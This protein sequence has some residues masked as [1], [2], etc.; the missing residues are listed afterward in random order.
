M[1]WGFQNDSWWNSRDR[2]AQKLTRFLSCLWVS[3]VL[4]ELFLCSPLPLP[5]ST[6]TLVATGPSG[7]WLTSFTHCLPGLPLLSQMAAFASLKL[8]NKYSVYIW[9][10]FSPSIHHSA[11]SELAPQWP[12]GYCDYCCNEHSTTFISWW[13]S[14]NAT[15][16]QIQECWVMWHV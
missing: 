11:D 16:T 3:A 8:N 6:S 14:L 2:Q 15:D 12:R 5:H 1:R 13:P 7:A 10:T 9:V 4:C